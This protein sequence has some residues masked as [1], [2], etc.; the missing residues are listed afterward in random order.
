[1]LKNSA[2]ALQLV[3]M[4]GFPQNHP[5]IAPVIIGPG[6]LL[7]SSVTSRWRGFLVEK[8]RCRPG[9]RLEG[10]LLDSPVLAMLCTPAWRGE[11]KGKSGQF[12]YTSKTQDALT[13]VPKG[14]LPALRSLEDC[15]LIYCAFDNRFVLGIGDEIGGRSL[16]RVGLHPGLHDDVAATLLKLLFADVESG[17][18]SDVLYG[19]SLAHALAARLIAVAERR[20]ASP[21]RAASLP[22][23][24][25]ARIQ[26]FIESRL[27]VGITLGELAAATDYSRSHFLRMFHATTGMTPHR[28]VMRRR[29]ERAR[30]LLEET[31][32]SIAQ[33]AHRCGFSSQAHLTLTFRKECGLTPGAYRRQL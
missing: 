27:D 9:D 14:P 12:V 5:V 8:Y 18:A 6:T 19:E 2:S 28:Y 3:A 10:N 11:Q 22:Q 1:V 24:K 29:I 30:A 20:A 17:N 33:I 13:F 15:E 4:D 16:W 26:E 25:L 21:C 31:D 32:L 7:C 23:R